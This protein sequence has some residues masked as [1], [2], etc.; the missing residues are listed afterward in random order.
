MLMMLLGV[1]WYAYI[2]SS[3]ATVMSSFDAQQRCIRDK[4][5][6][7]NE[8]IRGARLP[9][10]LAK[11]VRNFFEFKLANSKRVFL[12]SNQ[13]EA[14][15]L[16][17]ELSSQVRSE[18]LIFMEQ[19]LISR[20]P[21]LTNKVP[22]FIADTVSMFQPMVFRHGEYI[23]KEGSQADEMFFII[24][25]E[26]GIYYGEKHVLSLQEGNYFGEV[27]RSKQ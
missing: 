14:D 2:V 20:V 27:S 8:F 1:S 17:Y 4:M 11:Q 3:M 16:L 24:K 13:Y 12:L 15:E 21:F 22:Q 26:V 23:V 18:I 9:S 5:I 10:Q 25:G 7:V 6:C 19:D